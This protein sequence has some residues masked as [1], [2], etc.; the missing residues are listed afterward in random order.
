MTEKKLGILIHGAGRISTQYIK[1]FNNN[2]NTEIVAISSRR[3]ESC[4]ERAN[5]AGLKN[6]ELYTDYEK[7]LKQDNVDIV[8]ICTPQHLHCENTIL[9][10]EAGKH[11]VIEKPVAIS[12]NELKTMRDAV[13]KAK[14]K[15]IVG[16]VLRWNPLFETLKT[17]I[18]NN[19]F[20]NI[21]F[22]EVDYQNYIN[23]LSSGYEAVR[24]KETGVNASL[25]GGVHAIDALRWFAGRSIY[26]SAKPVEVFAYKGGLRKGKTQAY[27]RGIHRWKDNVNPLEYDAF[28]I[29]LVKFDNG[30][31]GKFS[32]NSECIMPYAFPIEIFGDK[33][34]VKDNRIWSHKFPGQNN[35]VEIPT[36]LPESADVKHHPF[37]AEVDHF[38]DCILNDKESHCN[39]ED[40]VLTHEIAFACLICY[41]TGEPVKLPLID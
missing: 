24:R 7:A 26:E 1:A 39:L 18:A 22:V 6:V 35:W 2:P 27:V 32:T 37:Q 28:E 21:Y 14:V 34:S 38:V 4:K 11:I 30:V 10:A 29:G 12:L 17:M 8:A 15:T 23:I 20:G 31:L 9:A 16:F 33:G 41:E 40:A 25:V 36:I 5:E 3:I 19:A 13:R